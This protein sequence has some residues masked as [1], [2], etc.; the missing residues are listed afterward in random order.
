MKV[1]TTNQ[2]DFGKEEL[3]T[4]Y[5]SSDDPKEEPKPDEDDGSTRTG[6]KEEDEGDIKP[7]K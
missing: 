2:L 6:D 5:L 7:Y 3:G 1:T 4:I